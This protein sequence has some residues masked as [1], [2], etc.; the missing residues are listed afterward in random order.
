MVARAVLL[1]AVFGL[2]TPLARAGASNSL[3]DVTPDGKYLLAANRDN[4]SVTVVDTASRKV[5]HEIKVGAL[6]E[7]VTWIGNGP[8]AA[9]TCYGEHRVVFVDALKGQRQQELTVAHEPY[10]IVADR[11]GKRA[12]VTHEYPGLVSEID[13]EARKVVRTMQA[14][15]FVRGLALSPD[16]QHLYVTEFYT[17]ILR[18]LDLASGK[19]VDHWQGQSSDNVCRNVVLHPRRPK[20][21]LS[22]IRSKVLVNDGG[23][24]IFPHLSVCDLRPDMGGRRRTSFAMD[25]YNGVYVVTN[26]WEAALSPDGKTLY[27]IYA[28]TNDMNVSRVIDDD[29]EEIQRVGGAVQLGQNPRAIRVSPD[30]KTVYI[31]NTLDFAVGVYNAAGMRPLATIKVCDPPK[32]PEWVR[33]KALFNTAKFPMSARRWVACASCHPD[34][35]NDARVW[36]QPEGLR[37]T[38][39]LFGVAHTHPLHWS[40]DRDEVQDFEYT[41]RSPLMRGAGLLRGSIKPKVG[42]HAAELEEKTSGRSKDLDALAIYC[43]SFDFTV[44]SPHIEGPGKL[45]PA[46]E[47]GKQLFFNKEVG[48]ASCH[49]G[50]YYTDSRLQKP[51]N[52]HD[53]GT[54]RDDPSERMGTKYDTPTLLGIYR[55]APYLHDGK[56][57]TLRDVLTTCNKE[58]RHGKTGHLSPAML[59]ELVAF[60]R[61]LPYEPPPTV[62]ANT[63]PFR[64]KE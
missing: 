30:G 31:Y 44:L 63:V 50:P 17:G 38:T 16:E 12:W 6:P 28:G 21:Y 1:V 49:S 32:T 42:Y 37:K 41:I 47:R 24:S 11:A 5:L 58:D 52:L 60:L 27:T 43:N 8:H 19:E 48:C 4:N 55:T 64:V 59:D 25:T 23:G 20:A 33:G 35:H 40:A 10:G 36:Q 57:K 46:A 45:T 34:G 9:V 61:S 53:I 39:A 26:A 29:Y 15:S 62:T 54:G 56:A 18:A 13:L 3:L 2:A 14:G 51:F 22:H 7:G